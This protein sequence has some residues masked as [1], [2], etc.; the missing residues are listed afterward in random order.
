MVGADKNHTMLPHMKNMGKNIS[1]RLKIFF[2][3][4]TANV[5]I[6]VQ[7]RE[8]TLPHAVIHQNPGTALV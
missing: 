1:H 6:H 4:L 5:A 8:L 7:L 3:F 2:F